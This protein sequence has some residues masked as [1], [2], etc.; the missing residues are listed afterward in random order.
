MALRLAIACLA[1]AAC[2]PACG[3]DDL[4]YVDVGEAG[5]AGGAGGGGRGG[6]G[7]GGTAPGCV[8]RWSERYGDNADEQFVDVAAAPGGDIIGVGLYAG[9]LSFGA[10]VL[11]AASLS[12]G[13]IASFDGNS[14]APLWSYPLNS[15]GTQAVTSVAV[16]GDGRIATAG[17]FDGE[18]DLGDGVTHISQG[19]FDSFVLYL[20][21]TGSLLDYRLVQGGGA[22]GVE[23][24][25]YGAGALF[26]TGS[27]G[28]SVDFGNGAVVALGT[29]NLFVARYSAQDVLQWLA[30]AG[31]VGTQVS[32][33][34]AFG[35]GDVIVA[36]EVSGPLDLD[37]FATVDG[38]GVDAFVARYRGSDGVVL[39]ARRWG[40]GADQRVTDVVVDAAGNAYVVGDA[41][42]TM[43]LE[44]E[45][46]PGEADDIFAIS[47]DAMGAVR[48][49]NRYGDAAFQGDAHAALGANG[50]LLLTGR[51]DGTIDFGDGHSLTSNNGGNGFVVE[52]DG[53]TGDPI[54]SKGFQSGANTYSG[55]VAVAEDG[56]FALAGGFSQ[57]PITFGS[58]ALVNQGGRDIFVALFDRTF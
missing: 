54:W 49:A 46:L 50:N 12:D 20:D 10:E 44:D 15:S 6:G 1:L 4:T 27:F 32:A 11:P 7:L 45:A 53:A 25:A 24:V 14:G 22:E 51:F 19:A 58:D 2:N 16:R 57:T 30:R 39:Y 26:A 41:S 29:D 35:N 38:G 13:V 52:L 33:T 34:L 31:A 21:A 18:I 36:G 37:M 47:L 8:H 48:W 40:D 28:G 55:R 3:V 42:G 17:T 9:G 56:A 23:S 43:D 5:G